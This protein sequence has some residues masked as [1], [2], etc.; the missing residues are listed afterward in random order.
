VLVKTL[1]QLKRRRVRL[2]TTPGM[3]RRIRVLTRCQ[4][5]IGATRLNG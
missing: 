1:K 5:V 4:R 2:L 3:M